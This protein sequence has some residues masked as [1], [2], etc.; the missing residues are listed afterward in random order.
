MMIHPLTG[1]DLTPE[2]AAAVYLDALRADNLG[3]AYLIRL[4]APP[5]VRDDLTAVFDR[6]A[7]EIAETEGGSDGPA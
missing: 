6:R 2:R 5:R 1:E 3:L 4:H 7:H